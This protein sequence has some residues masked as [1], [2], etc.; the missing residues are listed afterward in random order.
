MLWEG[1][2]GKAESLSRICMFKQRREEQ[3]I[4]EKTARGIIGAEIYQEK[5]ERRAIE[6]RRSRERCKVSGLHYSLD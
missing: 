5:I 1:G 6:A 2:W 3:E 4:R